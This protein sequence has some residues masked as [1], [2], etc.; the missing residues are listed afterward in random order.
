MSGTPYHSYVGRIHSKEIACLL[1]FFALGFGKSVK[2]NVK[3]LN[4]N[5]LMKWNLRK[6]YVTVYLRNF[7]LVTTMTKRYARH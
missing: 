6:M 2:K 3:S 5:F 1:A 4:V 7:G